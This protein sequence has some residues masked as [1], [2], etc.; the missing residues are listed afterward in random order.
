MLYKSYIYL[1]KII[2]CPGLIIIYILYF[3]F[4]YRHLKS[5]LA[6]LSLVFVVCKK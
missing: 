6:R 5:L 4:S 1:R 3:I 2:N